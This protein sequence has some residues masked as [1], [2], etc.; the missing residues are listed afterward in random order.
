MEKTFPGVKVYLSC[1]D[2]HMYLLEGEERIISKTELNDKKHLF[3]LQQK[4]FYYFV[5][6]NMRLHNFFY[7]A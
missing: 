7:I 5:F 3:L 6:S 4:S 1:R 2:E